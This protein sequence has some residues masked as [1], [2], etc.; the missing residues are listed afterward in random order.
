MVFVEAVL[1]I[2]PALTGGVVRE[3]WFD[4]F[5]KL[6]FHGAEQGSIALLVHKDCAGAGVKQR[7]QGGSVALP[8]G[9]H[10]D[11]NALGPRLSTAAPA[12]IRNSIGDARRALRRQ[13]QH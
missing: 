3:W 7:L 13:V 9:G 8:C 2:A 12:S 5:R 4:D 11:C 10:W 6:S 1:R